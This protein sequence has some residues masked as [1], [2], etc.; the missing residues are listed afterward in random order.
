VLRKIFPLTLGCLLL[1]AASPVYALLDNFETLIIEPGESIILSGTIYKSVSIHVKAGGSI[2]LPTNQLVQPDAWRLQLIAPWVKIEGA[3]RG[4]GVSFNTQG[5]GLPGSTFFGPGGSGYGGQGGDGESY[6]FSGGSMY[7]VPYQESTGSKGVNN[8]NGGGGSVRIDAMS[9]TLGA[10]AQFLVSAYSIPTTGGGGSGGSV[11]LNGIHT[12]LTGGY[13]IQ[14]AGGPGQ[15][16]VVGTGTVIPTP[17]PSPSVTM[18]PGTNVPGG[19]GGGGGRVKFFNYPS[20]TNQGGPIN[21]VGGTGGGGSAQNG[22]PGTMEIIPAPTPVQPVL[23]APPNGA[24]VGQAPTFTFQASDPMLSQFLQYEI[25]I[26]T[27]VTFSSLVHSSSQL[28]LPLDLGWN[29]RKYFRSNEAA[30]YNLP[31]GI[32]STSTTYY[33]RVHV[34]NNSGTLPTPW[35]AWSPVFQF[36]TSGTPNEPPD[37]PFLIYPGAGQMNISKLPALEMVAADQDGNSLTYSVILSQDPGLL[38]P[39]IFQSTY[40]GWDQAYYP[41][42]NTATCQI[43]NTTSFPDAL[44]PGVTYFWR[45]TASDP[46]SETNRS[47]IGTFVVVSPPAAPALLS[48]LDQAV[49]TNKNPRL[50]LTSQSPTGS[51]LNYLLELS[52]DN[53]QTIITFLSASSPGWTKTFYPS[54]DTASLIVPEAYTLVPGGIYSWRAQAFDVTNDNWS[55]T[56]ASQTFTVIT[57]PLLPQ[58][59]SPPD[60]YSAPDANLALQFYAVSE[61]GNTLTYRCELSADAFQTT[62][63]SFTQSLSTVGWTAGYYASGEIAT[64]TL[65]ASLDLERGRSYSWRVQAQDGISWGPWS[66]T[67]NFT[68]AN[69]LEIRSAKVFPNPAVRAKQVQVQI[70]LSVDADVTLR[71]FNIL[72]KELKSYQF[73]AQG[74]SEPAQFTLDVSTFASG[75]Y[76]CSLEAKSTLGNRQ[77]VK[78]LSV[79]K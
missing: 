65:P 41:S 52:S 78:R 73:T 37:K 19:G 66:E 60:Q 58:L 49:V 44:Q 4:V 14:A 69:N 76:F 16:R 53:F 50:E 6:T 40:P 72:G 10:T 36:T 77:V 43:Q 57:P 39:T 21:V 46:F 42:G 2:T 47:N 23:Q 38:N 54:G 15:L 13:M 7:D 68:L 63:A 28:T 33:W 70:V 79:V 64:F 30:N 9:L 67:R 26:S 11:L 17:S 1:M 34:S 48:P 56:S 31:T 75:T 32:L 62:L 3:I 51:P 20:F 27:N 8:P 22:Q 71:I 12:F 55:E 61:S 45:T 25:Q 24:I 59:V 35:S 74:G 18:T 5:S 29:L